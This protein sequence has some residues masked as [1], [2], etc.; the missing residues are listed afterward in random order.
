LKNQYFALRHGQSLANVAK[1]IASNP[2][3]AC[4]QYGLSELGKEQAQK[5]GMD[6]VGR[7]QSQTKAKG[8]AIVSSDLLRAKETAQFAAKAVLEAE[9]P[10]YTSDIV[11]DT[12]LRERGFGEWDGGSDQHYQDVWKDDAVDPS[13]TIKGVESVWNV[14]DRATQCVMEWDSELADHWIVCVAHGDVLQI[15]QTAF[16]KMDPSKHRL[17]EHLET[18][19]LRPLTL[20]KEYFK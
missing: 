20:A 14:T 5:A 16:S 11:M 1:I 9:I 8:I 6:L 17:L 12:R 4:H 3:V 19:T 10:L 7:F 15:L 2:D 13:H 18:A